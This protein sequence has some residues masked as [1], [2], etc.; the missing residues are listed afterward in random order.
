MEIRFTS[1]LSREKISSLRKP[2]INNS[3]DTDL[4]LKMVTTD[5]SM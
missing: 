3:T 2:P 5:C 4:L 1:R